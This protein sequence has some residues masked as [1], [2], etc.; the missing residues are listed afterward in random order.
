[1][2]GKDLNMA[3]Y[4]KLDSVWTGVTPY[5][6]HAGEFKPMQQMYKKV[7][8]KYELIYDLFKN[9]NNFVIEVSNDLQIG[10]NWRGKTGKIY[11]GVYGGA[12]TIVETTRSGGN[13]NVTVPLTIS[14]PSTFY[15][16]W[17]GDVT[18]GENPI[19]VTATGPVRVLS[20]PIE[21]YRSVYV[22]SGGY[23]TI[24]AGVKLGNYNNGFVSIYPVFINSN[25]LTFEDNYDF[26]KGLVKPPGITSAQ[27][28]SIP[29][30]FDLG[31]AT[32]L[33]RFF[34]GSQGT[35]NFTNWIMPLQ[36]CRYAEMFYQ[37]YGSLIGL[38]NLVVRYCDFADL[39]DMFSNSTVTPRLNLTKWCVPLV[40]ARPG[41]EWNPASPYTK[42]IAAEPVW[43]TCGLE[44]KYV[45][46]SS[47]FT[48]SWNSVMA[49]GESIDY[50]LSNGMHYLNAMP[51]FDLS[52]V[53]T[54]LITSGANTTSAPMWL[55]GWSGAVTLTVHYANGSS[56]YIQI[57][58]DVYNQYGGVFHFISN[59]SVYTSIDFWG[60]EFAGRVKI[61]VPAATYLTGI[62][63]ESN[64]GWVLDGE[65]KEFRAGFGQIIINTR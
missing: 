29:A 26:Y 33:Y 62:T 54:L 19:V 22:L 36:K 14:G 32:D 45:S 58:S 50:P 43:G 11:Y 27:S 34:N 16:R 21:Y 52:T 47:G 4:V 49:D 24:A 37:F 30:G 28:L 38:E 12:E 17:E 6:K 63:I 1:M 57:L 60:N 53:D 40:T 64:S 10:Y 55:Y 56:D 5:V 13:G 2:Y 59:S 65:H 61:T 46:P 39:T 42:A 7:N 41:Y 31:D 51:G 44:T 15:I 3:L 9:S 20:Y 25:S 18:G 48:G 8:G 23:V 35:L